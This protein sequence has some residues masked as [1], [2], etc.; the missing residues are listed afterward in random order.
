MTNMVKLTEKIH[1]GE[2]K[3]IGISNMND[4]YI[5]L[6]GIVGLH[7]EDGYGMAVTSENS[8]LVESY[9][10]LETDAPLNLFESIETNDKYPVTIFDSI[11]ASYKKSELAESSFMSPTQ[12][13]AHSRTSTNSIS[14]DHCH[15]FIS[16]M[17]DEAL[18]HNG[19]VDCEDKQYFIDTSSLK[20]DNDS[21]MLSQLYW[22]L[23]TDCTELLSGYFATMNIDKQGVTIMRDDMAQLVGYWCNEL[24]TYIFATKTD[25]IVDILDVV[26]VACLESMITP[27]RELVSF[28]IDSKGQISGVESIAAPKDMMLTSRTSK[29]FKDYDNYNNDIYDRYDEYE[30]DFA[31]YNKTSMK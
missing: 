26:G 20:T 15:P 19:V 30:D 8:N 10:Q 7:N 22:T 29:A 18:V 31:Y 11:A 1:N 27:V 25:M 23:G 3:N 12:L 2:L 6:K 5:E 28:K 16:P 17:Q 21:E 14:L 24:D 13:I 4:F 9:H